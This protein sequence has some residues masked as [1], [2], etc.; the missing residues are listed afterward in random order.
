MISGRCCDVPAA[1]DADVE[2]YRVGPYYAPWDGPVDA[3]GD[4]K[5]CYRYRDI[6]RSSSGQHTL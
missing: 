4:A 6:R 3:Q 2:Q 1:V 5:F